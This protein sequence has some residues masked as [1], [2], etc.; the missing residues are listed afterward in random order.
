MR[1]TALGALASASTFLSAAV[2]A[3]P[4]AMVLLD[5]ARARPVPVALYFPGSNLACTAAT[6]CPVA[7]LS[8]GYGNSHLE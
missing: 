4:A 8:P 1:L 2:G 5:E 7:L 3:A 6:P